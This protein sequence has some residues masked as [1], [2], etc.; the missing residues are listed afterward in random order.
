MKSANA[1]TK[2]K[3]PLLV[4]GTLPDHER[5]AIMAE[6]EKDAELKKEFLFLAS[7]RENLHEQPQEIPSDLVLAKIKKNIREDSLEKNLPHSTTNWW[8]NGAVA[9]CALLALQSFL[10]YNNN[11]LSVPDNNDI[12][13]L[14]GSSH[15]DIHIIFKND[16]TMMQVQQAIQQINGTI[17]DGPSAIGLVGIKITDELTTEQAI[18][19]LQT[20]QFIDDVSE[21]N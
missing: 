20:M 13:L 9:A 21:A 7:L 18:E 16:A 10:V 14:D 1:I 11:D 2:E 5:A 19:Q 15:P 8:R 6:I 12:K 4:N 17:V 3:L